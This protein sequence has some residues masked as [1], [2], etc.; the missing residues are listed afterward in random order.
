MRCDAVC[1]CVSD[2]WVTIVTSA[3]GVLVAAMDSQQNSFAGAARRA[4]CCGRPRACAKSSKGRS[5]APSNRKTTTLDV[6]SLGV[7]VVTIAFCRMIGVSIY[8]NLNK[9]C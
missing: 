2:A 6:F 3:A 7:F 1:G 5:K 8:V 4:S 9:G